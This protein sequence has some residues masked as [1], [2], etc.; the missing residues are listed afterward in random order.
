MA[1][2]PQQWALMAK[3]LGVPEIPEGAFDFYTDPEGA[4]LDLLPDWV[5]SA[6]SNAWSQIMD[7]D[8]AFALGKRVANTVGGQ[9]A[10][11]AGVASAAGAA[12]GAAA[13]KAA[14]GLSALG[15]T[16]AGAAVSAAVPI[17]GWAAGAIAFF[18]SAI[19]AAVKG[20]NW[21]LDRQRNQDRE[22]FLNAQYG[23]NR[24]AALSVLFP[25]VGDD[26][27]LFQPRSAVWIPRPIS[28]YGKAVP[29]N[30]V[31]EITP[32][33]YPAWT[34]YVIPGPYKPAKGIDS[35]INDILIGW[36]QD[37]W[38]DPRT[39]SQIPE[40]N[41]KSLHARFSSL[42][43]GSTL[44]W[45]GKGSPRK[46]DQDELNLLRKCLGNVVAARAAVVKDPDLCKLVEADPDTSPDIV[47]AASRS[48]VPAKAVA[49]ALKSL[50]PSN[51][52][53]A[54]D[55]SGLADALKPKASGG[56]GLA[57]LGFAAVA[58]GV[59]AMS[60]KRK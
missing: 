30:K 48:T 52:G 14:A 4:S 43:A 49:D 22:E 29:P 11:T 1:T 12:A 45:Q 38:A 21:N 27:D 46:I 32:A 53:L 44:T 50:P 39:I 23:F 51:S 10:K 18:A 34:P 15:A 13:A 41:I 54:M 36:Q 3:S 17:V 2:S 59:Y 7:A 16:S 56:G 42:R 35:R 25:V 31:F 58:A 26:E 57:L 20:V 47:S 5:S 28:R 19:A 8:D 9:V 33:F 60:R 6:G 40:A 37:A 24:G 55:L